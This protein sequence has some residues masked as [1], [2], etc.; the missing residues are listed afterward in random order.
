[1]DKKIFSQSKVF[2][3]DPSNIYWDNRPYR[4]YAGIVDN[5]HNHF[6][7][8]YEAYCKLYD[9]EQICFSIFI[10]RNKTANWESD[11]I[12][13]FKLI[14]EEEKNELGIV[15]YCSSTKKEFDNIIL[16]FLSF[17]NKVSYIKSVVREELP[18]IRC[19]RMNDV[20]VD[21]CWCCGNRPF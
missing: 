20:G 8:D 5:N 14:S 10:D 13:G 1:M 12:G 16:S 19:K 15:K 9:D 17:P 18:C 2:V 7:F 11:L 3:K 6:D 21:V 4:L